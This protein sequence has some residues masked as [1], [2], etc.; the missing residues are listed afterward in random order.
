MATD[1]DKFNILAQLEH[2]Q[3][4]YQGTGNADTTKW[5]WALNIH[6]DTLAS[7]VDHYN[8]LAFFAIA[9]NESIGRIRFKCLQNMANPIMPE[10]D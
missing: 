3:S 2:L 10:K 5:D 7:H 4:K 6:R 1:Y 8:R 9:K